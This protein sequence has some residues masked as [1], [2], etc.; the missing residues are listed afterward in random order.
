[1]HIFS[2]IN[3]YSKIKKYLEIR[4]TKNDSSDPP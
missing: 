2:Q 4:V 1:M 3:D